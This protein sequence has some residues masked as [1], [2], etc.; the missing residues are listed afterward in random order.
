MIESNFFRGNRQTLRDKLDLQKDD[1][2]LIP[3]AVRMQFH[4]EQ[5]SEFL[6]ESNFFYLTGVNEP[7]CLLMMSSKSEWLL[8][9][10]QD[11]F[12]S[13]WEGQLTPEEAKKK[14]EIEH[15]IDVEEGWSLLGRYIPNRVKRVFLLQPE[16]TIISGGIYTNPSQRDLLN[17]LQADFPLVSYVDVRPHLSEQRIIKQKP[18]LTAI[19]RAVDVTLNTMNEVFKDLKSGRFEYELSAQLTYGFKKHG[20]QGD[21]YESIVAGGERAC[22]IHYSKKDQTLQKNNFVLID[23]GARFDNYA[24]D[25]SRT[26]L[27][28]GKVSTR[29][30]EILDAVDE[31]HTFALNYLKPGV[32]FDQYEEAVEAEMGRV[33]KNLKLINDVSRDSIRNYYPHATSHFLGLEVHDVGDRSAE[34]REGMVLTV[35]PGIYIPEESIGVRFE[36][37]ILITATGIENLSKELPLT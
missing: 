7:E 26:Y 11:Q 31:V 6:Q 9:P 16:P 13:L 3:S 29:Q 27:V 36:D 17:R 34:F 10:K 15:V 28:E 25:I 33:L 37:N 5:A 20:A 4:S 32:R 35:E 21:A 30:Q 22:V 1:L 14:S 12:A 23:A 2:V 18:E 8:I 24:A 19:R